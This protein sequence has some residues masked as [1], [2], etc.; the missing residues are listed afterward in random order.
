M[1]D[2]IYGEFLIYSVEIFVLFCSVLLINFA[3]SVFTAINKCENLGIVYPSSLL[4]YEKSELSLLLLTS[5]LHPIYPTCLF[6]LSSY[7]D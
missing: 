2:R 4:G 5:G 6:L 7:N 3:R 1:E